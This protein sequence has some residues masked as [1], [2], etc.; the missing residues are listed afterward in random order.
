MSG[1][2]LAD[3]EAALSA[4]RAA[5]QVTVLGHLRPDADAVGS[6]CGLSLALTRRGARVTAGFGEPGDVPDQLRF[7]PG[8]EFLAQFGDIPAEPELLVVLDTASPER[9]GPLADRLDRAGT[10][11]VIDHHASN[12][13]FGDINLVDPAAAAAAMLI[14]ELLERLP[15]EL[16]RDIATCLYAGIAADT[17]SFR[18]G[19]VTPAVHR[20]VAALLEAGARPAP[21]A[22]ALFDSHS[23]GW[24][25]LVGAALATARIEDDLVWT[26]VRQADVAAAGAPEEEA[27]SVIGLLRGTVAADVAA[28]FKELGPQLWEVSVRSRERTDV[29]AVC[30]SLGGGGHRLAAGYTARGGLDEAVAEL[31]AGLA[32]LNEAALSRSRS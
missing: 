9:L 4:L 24:L 22:Q 1:P 10:V 5:D 32:Q 16:D 6:V 3:W 11:L 26:A 7:L 15:A 31:R 23:P 25:A 12:R 27:S 17:G 20:R 13:R 19:S 8:R 29:G 30:V 2:D 28:V 18:F 14:A 21:V